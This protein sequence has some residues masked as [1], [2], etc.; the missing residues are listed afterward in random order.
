MAIW[1]DNAFPKCHRLHDKIPIPG[2]R[3]PFFQETP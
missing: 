2:M 3:K 1:D